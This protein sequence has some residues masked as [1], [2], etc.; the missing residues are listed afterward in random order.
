MREFLPSHFDSS[1]VSLLGLVC[2]R[3]LMVREEIQESQKK[4]SGRGVTPVPVL[5]Q[6]VFAFYEIHNE[7]SRVMTIDL[8]G[9]W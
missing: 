6:G 2:G 4:T 5:S 1:V 9:L 3:W 7:S 8:A